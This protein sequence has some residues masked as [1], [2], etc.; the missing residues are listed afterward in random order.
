MSVDRLER[1][2]SLLRREIGEACF[3]VL[4]TT[5]VDLAAITVT[6]VETSRNLRHALV[7]ISILGHESERGRIL[8]IVANHH[9][10]FQRLINRD[11]KLKYTPVLQ[12]RLDESVAK[13]DH[14]LD[15]LSKLEPNEPADLPPAATTE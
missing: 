1:V 9:G 6:R 8:R 10:A 14:V 5:G 7:Y 4:G 15:V 11:L 3:H 12:F 2:N 13:G